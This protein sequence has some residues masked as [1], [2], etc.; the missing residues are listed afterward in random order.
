MGNKENQYKRKPLMKQKNKPSVFSKKQQNQICDQLANEYNPYQH[1]KHMKQTN[2]PM[3]SPN[4]QH[5]QVCD[6]VCNK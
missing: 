6:Q 3:G 2:K 4:P 5:H 1:K